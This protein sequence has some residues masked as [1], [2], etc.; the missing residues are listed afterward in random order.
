MK[1]LFAAV[2]LCF[3]L[4]CGA[5]GGSKGNAAG[6]QSGGGSDN[7]KG[8]SGGGGAGTPAKSNLDTTND[9]AKMPAHVDSAGRKK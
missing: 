6:S 1:T 9:S 4:A 3:L 5:C 2:G 7:S 8:S